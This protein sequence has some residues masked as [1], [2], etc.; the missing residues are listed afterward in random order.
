MT[1]GVTAFA[2]GR[3]NT[4]G[5]LKSN[6]LKVQFLQLS[7]DK[8]NVNVGHDGYMTAIAR[9]NPGRQPCWWAARTARSPLPAPPRR[10]D[11]LRSQYLQ[12]TVETG[13]RRLRQRPMGVG[14]FPLSGCKERLHRITQGF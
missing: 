14:T 2:F 12:S 8:L 1:T 5:P 11:R 4:L 9:P 13:C 3:V 6:Y 10:P 7:K